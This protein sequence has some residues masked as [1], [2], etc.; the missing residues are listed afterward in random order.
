MNLKFLEKEISVKVYIIKIFHFIFRNSREKHHPKTPLKHLKYSRR[1]WDGLIK[2]WRLELA[3]FDP[4]PQTNDSGR[5]S[6]S[7]LSS[8]TT[9][10]E[11][12]RKGR[13]LSDS[14]RSQNDSGMS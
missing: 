7:D 11:S 1:A 3:C 5:E 4:N 14:D 6:C 12:G 2:V 9:S 13:K 10:N 8:T